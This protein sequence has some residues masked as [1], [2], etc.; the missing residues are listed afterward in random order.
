MKTKTNKKILSIWLLFILIISFLYF[1]LYTHLNSLNSKTIRKLESNSQSGGD[2]VQIFSIIVSISYIIFIVMDIF[3]LVLISCAKGTQDCIFLYVY[4]A[5]NGY[6]L[7]CVFTYLITDHSIVF[8]C[9]GFSLGICFIG[10]IALIII[11]I[12]R[13][14]ICFCLYCKCIEYLF[15]IIPEVWSLFSY[16][17]EKECSCFHDS[18]SFCMLAIH[19]FYT[20]AI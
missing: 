16:S 5:N 13:S 7:L 10:T 1:T 9:S 12:K 2:G 4:L 19:Y 15:T 11:S 3:I 8:V 18:S 6:L 20:I 14:S 17:I